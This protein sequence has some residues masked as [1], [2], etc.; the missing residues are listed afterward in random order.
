M[1]L[2]KIFFLFLPDNTTIKGRD[3]QTKETS[4]NILYGMMVNRIKNCLKIFATQMQS[5]MK[6]IP[7]RKCFCD[8]LFSVCLQLPSY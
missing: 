6:I 3:M 4:E 2:G 1:T 5:A 7:C 8:H